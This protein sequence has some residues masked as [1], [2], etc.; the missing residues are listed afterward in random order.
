[1]T[2]HMHPS[3]LR[4]REQ[5]LHVLFIGPALAEAHAHFK[6]A[7]EIVRCDHAQTLSMGLDMVMAQARAL[8]FDCVIVD[9]RANNTPAEVAGLASLNACGTLAL[10]VLPEMVETYSQIAG[11]DELLVHPVERMHIV[12]AVVASAQ[13][14]AEQ[15]ERWVEIPRGFSS[16]EP[17]SAAPQDAYAVPE[18]HQRINKAKEALEALQEP[19]SDAVLETPQDTSPKGEAVE[20]EPQ[21]AKPNKKVKEKKQAK[22]E[23]V[24]QALQEAAP[25]DAS[26]AAPAKPVETAPMVEAALAEVVEATEPNAEL[27]QENAPKKSAVTQGFESSLSKIAEADQSVWQRFVPLA[28]FF[29]K[30]LAIIVLTSLFLT[31]LAYG[32]MIVFFMGS[33]SWSL[34]FE[35]S[36]GHVLV[37]KVER[38][39]S[40]MS[41]RRN[42]VRQDL[43]V[44]RAEGVTAD[45]ELRDGKLQLALTQRTIEEELRLQ[46]AQQLEI[47][48]HIARLKEVIRDFNALNGKG[49]FA[50][51]LESA[52]NKR[53]ITRKSLNS[54]TLAVL[55]TLHRIATVQN[56]I[57]VKQLE[58][59]RV[60]RRIEFLQSLLAEIEQ[61]ELR[62]ITSAGSDL[63]HLAR[64]VIEAKNRIATAKKARETA[65]KRVVRL[66]NSNEVIS[67]NIASLEATPAARARF[68]PVM[69][70]FVPYHNAASTREGTQLYSCVFSIIVCSRVGEVGKPVEGETT[71]VHPLF[72]KPMRGNFVEAQFDDPDAVREELMHAG[73]GP[74]WF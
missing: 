60:D 39:L 40:S 56:E 2:A 65:N 43:T 68:E 46:S 4:R 70:L 53:L 14:R 49:G 10:L 37:E 47:R 35:L 5:P 44:A 67:A 19:P 17:L 54:G 27:P 1:M 15:A 38:D 16:S 12:E 45:R 71:S 55:E 63:A 22:A 51:N 57:S 59:R 33:S 36:R 66:E 52:F 32:A 7:D 50:K 74:L 18:V 30:K 24:S 72:S 73:R 21:A 20:E 25:A 23:P 26:T 29:Y 28:N 31:F 64:E 34:P 62:V 8:A 58:L 3:E 61:P 6:R 42:Q 13:N 11:I 69:V 48:Q 9:V 41:L